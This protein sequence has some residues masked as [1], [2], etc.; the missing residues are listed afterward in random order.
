MSEKIKVLMVD[1]EVRFRDTTSTLLKRRGFVTTM[2]ASGEEALGLIKKAPQDVVILDVKMEGMDGH[3]VLAEIKKIAPET[4]VIM[5]TGHA[6]PESARNSLEL[7]AFD[8]LTKPCDIDL[9]AMKINEAYAIKTSGLAGIEKKARDIM[10]SISD[11]TTVSVNTTV[12]EA[13]GKLLA[14]FKS[15]VSS[16]RIMETGHRSLLVF[17]EKND[18]IGILSIMDLIKGIRPAYLSTARSDTLQGIEYSS[19]FWGG[20][21]GLFSIQMKTLAEKKVGEVMSERPPLVDE[22]TNLMQV[23]DLMYKNQKRRLIV[24]SGKKAIGIIR[25]QDLFFEMAKIVLEGT[26]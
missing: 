11:Y 5:L 26:K 15:L 1:D 6:S 8:Y 2:A 17:D 24:T 18:L 20:W 9:L 19:L 10:I 7:A 23:A 13:I 16:S 21:D 3:A 22:N 14:S 4:Q 25:E 12:R